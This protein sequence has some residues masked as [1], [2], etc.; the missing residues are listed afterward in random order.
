MDL[1]E[2]R[3]Q[4]RNSI[5]CLFAEIEGHD[6]VIMELRGGV[7]VKDCDPSP[8][9]KARVAVETTFILHKRKQSTTTRA[10]L[11]V[12]SEICSELSLCTAH[13]YESKVSVT[14]NDEDADEGEEHLA[15]TFLV[16]VMFTEM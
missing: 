9:G 7:S 14:L 4:S 16:K 10:F 13:G 12:L 1:L 3:Q 11:S 5:S 6:D 15:Y 8:S 2:L